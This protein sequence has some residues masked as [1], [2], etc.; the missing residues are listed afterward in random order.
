MYLALKRQ[1]E[2][3]SKII[4]QKVGSKINSK[5]NAIYWEPYKGL[6]NG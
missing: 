1:K 6:L 5:M 3:I 2:F 4:K